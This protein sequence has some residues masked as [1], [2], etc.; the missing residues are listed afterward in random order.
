M[1]EPLCASVIVPT[2]NRPDE[3]K[4]LLSALGRQSRCD[5]E[6]ILVDDAS[7]VPVRNAVSPDASPFRIRFHREH[8]NTPLPTIFRFLKMRSVANTG[9]GRLR[10]TA[11][12]RYHV[13]LQG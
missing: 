6:V 1:H 5:F 9:S 13:L 3:L 8:A 2:H 12:E 11:S 4:G 10:D 7:P